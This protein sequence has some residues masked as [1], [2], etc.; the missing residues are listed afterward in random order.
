MAD[1][2]NERTLLKGVDKLDG[3]GAN[4]GKIP[5]NFLYSH[6]EFRKLCAVFMGITHCKKKST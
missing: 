6:C 4:W 1:F 3:K 2:F 5:K